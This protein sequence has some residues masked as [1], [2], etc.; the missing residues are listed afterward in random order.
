[1]MLP[2]IALMTFALLKYGWLFVKVQQVNNAARHG[3]RVAARADSVNADVDTA[4]ATLMAS[5]WP[6]DSPPADWYTV[7]YDPADVDTTTGE[8]VTVTITVTYAGTLLDIIS[9][10]LVPVPGSIS[11]SASMAREG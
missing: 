9:M 8:I 3:A 4:I 11:S 2:L 10:P 7:T 6:N 5:V 1:M